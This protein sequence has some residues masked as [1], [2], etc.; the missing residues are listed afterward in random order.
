MSPIGRHRERAPSPVGLAVCRPHPLGLAGRRSSGA[1][2]QR[3]GG[4]QSQRHRGVPV[5]DTL[6][7]CPTCAGWSGLRAGQRQRVA[8]ARCHWA[9]LEALRGGCNEQGAVAKSKGGCSPGAL[10]KRSCHARAT[11]ATEPRP[12]CRLKSTS[13]TRCG[14]TGPTPLRGRGLARTLRSQQHPGPRARDY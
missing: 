3:S 8:G 10:P 14:P 9:D 11:R 6:R 2:A 12:T 5:W 7:P 1:L 13:R 4:G